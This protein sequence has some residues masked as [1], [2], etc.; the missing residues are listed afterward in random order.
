MFIKQY[1][2]VFYLFKHDMQDTS[3]SFKTYK[4]IAL[5]YYI[6]I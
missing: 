6:L 5:F 2:L 4:Y 1:I 3:I